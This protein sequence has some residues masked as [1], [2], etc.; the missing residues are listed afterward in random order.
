MLALD[1][2]YKIEKT[3]VGRRFLEATFCGFDFFPFA[4]PVMEIEGSDMWVHLLGSSDS[5]G[6]VI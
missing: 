6:F 4:C 3:E 5:E 1:F 2:W